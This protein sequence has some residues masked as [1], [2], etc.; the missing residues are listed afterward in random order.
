MTFNSSSAESRILTLSRASCS[1]MLIVILASRGTRILFSIFRSRISAGA[2]SFSKRTRKR[3]GSLGSG[4]SGAAAEAFASS[5]APDGPCLRAWPWPQRRSWRSARLSLPARPCPAFLSYQPS[6]VTYGF[7]ATP[8][9]AGLGAVGGSFEAD[10]DRGV[11]SIAKNH[12]VRYI[13]RRFL[14]DDS[15]G[16]L[17]AARLAVPLDDIEPLDYDAAALRQHAHHLAGFAAVAAGDNHHRVI[18]LNLVLRRRHHSTSGASE[19]IFKNFFA[20]SSRATGPKMRV[21]I[22][23]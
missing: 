7:S 15:A 5:A 8:A 23:S 18:L 17:R 22:G 4:G 14:L 16:A 12:D 1:A 2:I 10:A 19:I 6:V 20:R 11:A 21:P 9:D 13:D 3:A